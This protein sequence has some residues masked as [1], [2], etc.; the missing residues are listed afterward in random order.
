MHVLVLFQFLK[1]IRCGVEKN[2]SI[3]KIIII[4]YTCSM[5]KIFNVDSYNHSLHDCIIYTDYILVYKSL[6]YIIIYITS[7]NILL[8]AAQLAYMN[9]YMHV[10]LHVSLNMF[11]IFTILSFLIVSEPIYQTN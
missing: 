10:N 7:I 2:S 9:M 11:S 3:I 1:I 4:N 8:T 6:Y 5:N